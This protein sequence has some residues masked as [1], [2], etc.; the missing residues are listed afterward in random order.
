MKCKEQECAR[1][2]VVNLGSKF[3]KLSMAC[4][5]PSCILRMNIRCQVK[6]HM[7][8]LKVINFLCL[9]HIN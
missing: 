1:G 8:E 4:Q 2:I 5:C 7:I 6:P 9:G 3:D